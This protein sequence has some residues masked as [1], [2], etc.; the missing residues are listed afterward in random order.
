MMFKKKKAVLRLIAAILCAAFGASDV[1]W[2]AP[3]GFA[4]SRSLT[5]PETVPGD[6]LRFEAPL[7]FCILKE[8]HRGPSDTFIIHIQDAHANL[9]GQE[10]LAAALESLMSRYGVSLVLSEG[11]S[12]DCSLTPL[13]S[14]ASQ[15]TWQRV[16]KSYLVKGKLRGEEYQNLVSDR[17]MKIVGLEDMGLYLESVEDYGRLAQKREELL[18]QIARVR[19]AVGKLKRRVYPEELIKYE[20]V[21][22]SA[23]ASLSVNPAE[24]S[25]LTEIASSS[26]HEGGTPRN[27]GGVV[28]Q[29]LLALAAEKSIGLEK[30]PALRRL[31]ALAEKEKRVDFE[32]AAL[33]QA[34]L[35][36]AIAR[37]GG[38][39]DLEAGLEKVGRLKDEKLSLYAYFQN[40]L[41]IA[42]QNKIPVEKFP[43]YLKYGEMLGEYARMDLGEIPGDL[44]TLENEVYAASLVT[45]DSQRLRAIDRYTRLLEKA[46]RIQMSADEFDRFEANAP[47]FS[48]APV[49]GFLNRR[50]AEAGYFADLVPYDGLEEEARG[51]LKKFYGSVAGRDLAFLANTE[52]ALRDENQKVAVLISGGYHT[53]HLKKLFEEKGWSYA[54]LAPL[55]TAETNQKKYE[56][57]LLDP[58]K[59]G[60]SGKGDGG[61]FEVETPT[62]RALSPFDKDKVST[63][64]LG[65]ALNDPAAVTLPDSPEGLRKAARLYRAKIREVE[66]LIGSTAS[67]NP[68]AVEWK[69]R[70][71]ALDRQWERASLTGARHAGVNYTYKSLIKRMSEGQPL[72]FNKTIAPGQTLDSKWGVVRLKMLADIG[73]YAGRTGLFYLARD[74]QVAVQN[75]YLGIELPSGS[76]DV[77]KLNPLVAKTR[78]TARGLK[79]Q[80]LR[81]EKYFE[82]KGEL[83]SRPRDYQGDEGQIKLARKTRINSISHLYSAFG[84]RGN[85]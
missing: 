69:Q 2:A 51:L 31:A 36:E 60:R 5:P 63:A 68:S 25:R 57:L 32:A 3:Q 16:A 82:S 50:L 76:I 53:A 29:A 62:K 49:R 70:L 26:R 72:I 74:L 47:D 59:S 46:C 24:P 9:S 61:L 8:I 15:K 78:A 83:N 55:V 79:T 81:W 80:Y 44:E 56:K 35:L 18:G 27:D 75:G 38:G 34:A 42:K 17:P 77:Q 73:N 28:F 7:D 19:S 13:K 10:N 64:S 30:Y 54:V 84:G 1:A 4:A 43:D 40:T 48:A 58:L 41:N 33:E 20:A 45:E 39:R 21:P 23:F 6:P 37:S 85:T 22:A 67:D 52:K 65:N 14:V 71:E 12:G 66:A 11:G